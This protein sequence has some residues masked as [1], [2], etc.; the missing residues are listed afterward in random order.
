W[1]GP[2]FYHTA[3]LISPPDAAWLEDK[4]KQARK[5]IQRGKRT[6][7][8]FDEVQ[9][10]TRWSEVV[11]KCFDEDRMAN[12]PIDT[13]LL[14]SSSLLVQR[15]LTESLAGRFEIIPFPHWSFKECRQ[16]FGISLDDYLFYG[17][18]P[19]ALRLLLDSGRDAERWGEYVRNALIETVLSKDILLLTP[20]T[21]PALFR[22]VFNLAAAHPAEILSLNKMLGQLQEAG[23]ASTIASYLQLLD[24]AMFVKPL[25]K[26]SGS[27]LRQKISSPKLLI[28]NNALINASQA[29]VFSQ[30][31]KNGAAWGRLMENAMGAS[32]FNNSMGQGVELAYWRD[33][34]RE[35]DFVI[36]WGERLLAVEVKSAQGGLRKGSGQFL[37]KYPHARLIIT[38]PERGDIPLEALINMTA[39]EIFSAV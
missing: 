20:V 17:G 9:K 23:N 34:D 32:V 24:A 18:Y 4:W 22:Q 33:R 2:S 35:V 36:R 25:E 7:L 28:L 29:R 14:G 37:K 13:V 21:K 16:H 3:D 38:A 31:K 1:E 19:G 5:K 6:L 12:K 27:R 26:Y 11:K 30:T 8:V 39:Q 10:I 15:G